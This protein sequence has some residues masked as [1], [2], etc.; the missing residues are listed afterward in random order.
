MKVISFC[1]VGVLCFGLSGCG[2]VRSVFPGAE[3]ESP[4]LDA[5]P[6]ES[7]QTVPSAQAQTVEEFD[8]T[9]EAQK[10]AARAAP[11][12]AE[13]ALGETIASLGAPGEP[14]FWM[15]TPLVAQDQAGRV[16]FADTGKSVQVEL[17]PLNGPSTAGSQLSLAAF[18]VIEAPLTA[19]VELQVFALP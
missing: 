18:R 5:A 1:I 11:E 16:L 19:L 10:E 15:K 17:R 3:P 2:L 9:T 8:T 4:A 7:E 6:L 14:G 12:S 13:Q